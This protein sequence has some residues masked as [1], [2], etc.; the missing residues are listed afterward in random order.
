MRHISIWLIELFKRLEGGGF[1]R[2]AH[3]APSADKWF[4]SMSTKRGADTCSH[5]PV[6]Y[7][8]G[9]GFLR[10]TPP[11]TSVPARGTRCNSILVPT[12]TNALNCLTRSSKE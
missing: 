7:S 11:K 10:I 8:R 4:A 9:R 1:T 5:T 6:H 12:N 3:N 2:Y